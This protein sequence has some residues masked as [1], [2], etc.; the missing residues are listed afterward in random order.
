LAR[1]GSSTASQWLHY[2]DSPD[3]QVIPPI[4]TGTDAESAQESAQFKWID[5]VNRSNRALVPSRREAPRY[6]AAPGSP[7]SSRPLSRPSSRPLP[8]PPTAYVVTGKQ[9]GVPAWLL[10]GVAL[11]ESRM[12][13]GG[14]ALPYPW[15][16]DVRGRAERHDTYADARDA[17]TGYLQRGIT[18]VDCGVMQVNWHSHSGLLRS[19]GQALDPYYNLAVG[20]RILKQNYA[21]TGTWVKAVGIYHTGSFAGLERRARAMQYVVGVASQLRTHGLTFEEAASM[22]VPFKKGGGHV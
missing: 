19:A 15:T 11:Q 14:S 7:P 22:D 20:A 21:A 10:F 6:T 12:I 4:L 16:L 18:N 3:I 17:L 2:S 13:F 1:G 9:L 8:A 5:P